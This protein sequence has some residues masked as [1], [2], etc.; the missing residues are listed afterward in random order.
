MPAF[1]DVLER[2]EAYYR[3]N[4]SEIR[5]NGA[6]LLDVLD[7]LNADASADAEFSRA[8]HDRARQR[9][10]ESFDAEHGGFGGAP[11]FPHPTNLAFLLARWRAS[12]RSGEAD[13]GAATMIEHTL[14]AMAG[15]GL[16]DHLGGGFYRY[17]VDREWMIPHFEKMLYDNAQLLGVYADAYA[18]FG[19]VR[20]RHVA[21]QTADWV[22]TDMTDPA[23]AFYATLDA[24]S[25]GGEGAFYVWT[26]D[27]IDAVLAPGE[28]RELKAYFGL[29]RP[30]NFEGKAWHLR[31]ADA[32]LPRT[33]S[34]ETARAK[35]LTVRDSRPRPGR[36]DKVLVAWNGLMVAGLAKAARRLPRPKLADAA[37]RA[38]DFVRAELWLDG[39]LKASYKDGRARFDAYLDDYAFLGAGL[40]ELLQCRWRNQDLHFATD[41]A[42][43]L[44]ARFSDPAG[45][46]FFTADDHE[47]LI[48]RPK[49]L[50]D[51]SI[52]SGNA[53]AALVLDT[54]GHLLG[55]HRYLEAAEKTLK[56]ALP[57]LER[58]P[59]AHA[60]LLLG[61]ERQLE[62]PELVV[63]RG[64]ADALERWRAAIDRIY[65]ARRLVFCIPDDAGALPGLLGERVPGGAPVAYVCAGMSCR[66]PIHDLEEL[67]ATLA[68]PAA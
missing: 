31:I 60:T 50:A 51:E 33:D 13:T 11:K 65:D 53:M 54:L 64:T 16:Y 44:I 1:K 52:P 14:R 48:H 6:K 25:P 12:T 46:F 15:G 58:Y 59:E 23:G 55:E 63:V 7:N 62:P 35:L 8:P 24:D 40:V 49:P 19:H 22:L 18:A 68:P 26:P 43:V 39:R 30:A 57:A 27:E 56:A 37:A 41:L 42:D 47:R 38:V 29:T 4:P 9:L 2:V 3:S 20:Y 5:D 34:L 32:G 45:G 67:E 28:A 36:D 17:C 21:T 10:G 66:A 61:T